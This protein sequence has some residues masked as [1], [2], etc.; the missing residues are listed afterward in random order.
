MELEE[1]LVTFKILD[2][3]Y[4]YTFNNKDILID[5]ANNFI[6]RPEL[7]EIIIKLLLEN[8]YKFYFTEYDEL[9]IYSKKED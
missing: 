5:L 6:F 7:F 9:Y 8:N 1:L 4:Y 3:N 2:I